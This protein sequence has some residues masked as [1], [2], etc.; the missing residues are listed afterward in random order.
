[1]PM[2]TPHVEV[3]SYVL[4]IL[5]EDEN[6]AFD[7]HIAA[8]LSCQAE[9]REL[10]DLPDVLDD[11]KG[12]GMP[13]G[14]LLDLFD[15]VAERRRRRRGRLQL[16]TAVAAAIAVAVP[17]ATAALWPDRAGPTVPERAPVSTV[18]EV[19][20]HAE[21]LYA[22]T[23]AN[24]LKAKIMLMSQGWGTQVTL[25]LSGISGPLDCELVAIS[26]TGEKAPV[27]TWR[28]PDEASY[29]TEEA[30][31]PLRVQAGTA[32]ARAEIDRFEIR[33]AS[34]SSLINVPA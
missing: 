31:E 9:L 2:P 15:E 17:I 13:G 6:E 24:R 22:T 26:R 25:E 3:A 34:G 8:C 33:T 19:P 11:A 4:G 10:Y 23:R 12:P 28:V 30:S 18:T 7:A 14:P 1:M 20:K 21:T 16:A 32:L 27:T 29:G 5:D